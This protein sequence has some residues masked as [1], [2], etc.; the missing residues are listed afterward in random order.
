MI[1]IDSVGLASAQPGARVQEDPPP[2]DQAPG[3]A[4]MAVGR[5]RRGVAPADRSV[6][7]SGSGLQS[8]ADAT[9]S[10]S[11]DTAN[12]TSPLTALERVRAARAAPHGG[13]SSASVSARSPPAAGRPAIR[14]TR[15]RSP[16]R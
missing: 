16:K 4:P 12:P 3:G 2:P 11:C 5:R 6:D 7:A 1:G 9:L 15:A 13:F 8:S 10:P 14:T